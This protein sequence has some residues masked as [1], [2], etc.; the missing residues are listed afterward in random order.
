MFALCP[1]KKPK[2]KYGMNMDHLP[3]VQAYSEEFAFT[4]RIISFISYC[5][6]LHFIHY[7]KQSSEQ[8]A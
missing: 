1:G 2:H 7:I 5:V 8:M 4:V 3:T 6:S